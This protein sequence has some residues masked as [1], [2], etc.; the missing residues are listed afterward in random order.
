MFPLF[1]SIEWR[2]GI[3]LFPYGTCFL[4][5]LDFMYS[6]SYQ[7]AIIK[8]FSSIAWLMAH[9]S[10]LI[11]TLN[12]HH[13]DHQRLLFI[14]YTVVPQNNDNP[15]QY[16]KSGVWAAGGY[17]LNEL[18]E[19]GGHCVCARAC[20]CGDHFQHTGT[21]TTCGCQS[22]ARD[23]LNR[24]NGKR[25]SSEVPR[26]ATVARSFSTLQFPPP[27]PLF[28]LS[29]V[30]IGTNRD[31]PRSGYIIVVIVTNYQVTRNWVP[32]A[33]FTPP[34]IARRHGGSGSKIYRLIIESCPSK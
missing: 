21:S 11:P 1:Q 14:H 15:A 20:L 33:L 6:I 7:Y 26:P 31:A 10:F 25:F 9:A 19:Y 32:L 5:Y 24:T 23:E 8:H 27:L 34:E 4:K 29:E 13:V 17:T 28:V 3:L 12:V 22:Y 30:S 16:W 18:S 2:N